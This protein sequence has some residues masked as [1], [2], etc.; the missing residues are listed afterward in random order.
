MRFK[1]SNQRKAVMARINRRSVNIFWKYPEAQRMTLT[2]LGEY[3]QLSR[4]EQESYWAFR[5]RGLMHSQALYE[6][7]GQDMI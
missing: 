5:Q 2:E 1:N 3:E 6:T 7:I 4:K